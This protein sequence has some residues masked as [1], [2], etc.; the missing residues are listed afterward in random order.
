MNPIY[1]LPIALASLYILWLMYL[2]IM[3]LKRVMDDGKMTPVAK[4][5]ASPIYYFGWVLDVLVNW[6]VLS[7]IL[8]EP[9]HEYTFTARLKR[10]A[11]NEGY[12]GKFARWMAVNLLDPYD[13]SGK[14]I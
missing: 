5:L 11:L 3:N 7:I 13:P 1:L 8:L 6:V 10:H 2:A 9:P 14:H 4:Y 12:R